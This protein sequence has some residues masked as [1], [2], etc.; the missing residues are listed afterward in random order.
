MFGILQ[1]WSS[2]R[3]IILKIK[4]RFKGA[5]YN[6]NNLHRFLAIAV[7]LFPISFI[8]LPDARRYGS[9]FRGL[10]TERLLVGAD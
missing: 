10:Q 3:D 9:L 7:E 8:F 6:E 2:C 4:K 5:S 1:A